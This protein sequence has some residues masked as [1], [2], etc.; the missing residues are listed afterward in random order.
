MVACL[1]EPIFFSM[2]MSFNL[3]I[4]SESRYIS[5]NITSFCLENTFFLWFVLAFFVYVNF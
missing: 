4:N 3:L 5:K 2:L 1:L